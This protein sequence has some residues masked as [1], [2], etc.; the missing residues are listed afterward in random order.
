VPV[1][2]CASS[3]WMGSLRVTRILS[4]SPSGKTPD[5]QPAELTVSAYGDQA[6]VS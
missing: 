3:R 4:D 6:R 1:S 5:A 2:G